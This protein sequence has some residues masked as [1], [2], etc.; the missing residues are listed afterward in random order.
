MIS[1]KCFQLIS[2]SLQGSIKSGYNLM[3][4]LQLH[5]NFP[6]PPPATAQAKAMPQSVAP[7]RPVRESAERRQQFAPFH[8]AQ[9]DAEE[10]V[11]SPVPTNLS[12]HTHSIKN[13][14]IKVNEG[15]F[16]FHLICL[17][18]AHCA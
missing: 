6:E 10:N 3:H 18:S 2:L 4:D 11:P 14:F 16:L 1:N 15:A 9:A 17:L 7:E 13:G 8:C 12:N 5:C